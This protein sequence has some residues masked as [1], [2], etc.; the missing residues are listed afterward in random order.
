MEIL[1]IGM[2]EFVFIVVIALI[3]LGPKDMQKAGK[4]IGKFL[5]DIITSDGWKVFQQTSRE[6]RTLPNRLM[7]EANEEF[8][9][10]GDKFNNATTFPVRH[11]EP[12]SESNRPDSSVSAPNNPNAPL[13][14]Q[15]I[16]ENSPQNKIAPPTP[17]IITN[18]SDQGKDA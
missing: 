15:P 12:Q 17:E 6:L 3:V 4:T 10:I 2:S 14:S 11:R 13:G 1:G 9:Q 8:N 16:P 5:R 18:E 7:R